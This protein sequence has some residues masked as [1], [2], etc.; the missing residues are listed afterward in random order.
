M[1]KR[2]DVEEAKEQA[3][4]EDR[5]HAMPDPRYEPG[6][7]EGAEKVDPQA[8]PRDPPPDAPPPPSRTGVPVPPASPGPSISPD[9]NPTGEQGKAVAQTGWAPDDVQA[10][11]SFGTQAWAEQAQANFAAQENARAFAK[12]QADLRIAQLA[13]QKPTRGRIVIYVTPEGLE[14]PAVVVDVDLTQPMK[15]GLYAMTMQGA[16]NPDSVPYNGGDHTDAARFNSWHW[17]PRV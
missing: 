2:A 5:V 6:A 17:P 3:K 15:V 4:S 10:G 13:V 12:Q 16:K 1:K 11:G 7:E 14:V 8:P 9:N